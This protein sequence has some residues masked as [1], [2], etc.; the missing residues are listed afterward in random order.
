MNILD[1]YNKAKGEQDL[2]LISLLGKILN[3]EKFVDSYNVQCEVIN[4][5]VYLY[6]NT[7]SKRNKLHRYH[8]YV[9]SNE[10]ILISSSNII[11]RNKNYTIEE[12]KIDFK[13]YINHIAN[14]L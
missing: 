6:F 11:D 4:D 1:L 8:K 7:P 2:T 14:K 12:I 13:N 3:K 9:S 10:N 5:I